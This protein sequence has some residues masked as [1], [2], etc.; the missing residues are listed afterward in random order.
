MLVR[1]VFEGW[2]SDLIASTLGSYLDLTK[3]RLRISLW[4]GMLLWLCLIW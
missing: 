4:E 2:V 1:T 3:E